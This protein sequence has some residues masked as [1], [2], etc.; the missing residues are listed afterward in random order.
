MLKNML[1]K[2]C[3][4]LI[5]WVRGWSTRVRSSGAQRNVSNTDSVQPLNVLIGEELSSVEFV[6]DYI[7]FR[8]DGPCI[9]AITDPCII[10]GDKQYTRIDAGFCDNLLGLI[11]SSVEETFLREGEIISIHFSDRRSINISLRPEDLQGISVEAATFN[12][13]SGGLWIW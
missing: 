13:G 3:D 8:F 5:K 1:Y 11:G 6:R 2:L 10:I 12:E 9:T 4:I 7:Q